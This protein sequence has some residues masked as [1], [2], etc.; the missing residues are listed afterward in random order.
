MIL[1]EQ[2]LL[3]RIFRSNL[4]AAKLFSHAVLCALCALCGDKFWCYLFLFFRGFRAVRGY[5]LDDFE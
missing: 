1:S 5:S 4:L 2:R 3:F